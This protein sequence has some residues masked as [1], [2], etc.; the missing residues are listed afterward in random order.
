MTKDTLEPRD[1]LKRSAHIAVGIPVSLAA[2]LR[3]R[4]AGAR[5]RIEGVRDRISDEARDVFARSV[6]EGEHVV[7]TVRRRVQGRRDRIEEAVGGGVA[8][9]TDVGRGVATML[10][11]PFV[12]VDQIDGIGPAYAEKLARAGVMSTRALIERCATSDA[13]ARLADQ[14]DVPSA[15]IERW[16]AAADL[17]RVDG[18]GEEHM[19]LLNRLGVPSVDALAHEDPA[20][21]RARTIALEN[22][23]P[24]RVSAVPSQA[25]F[26]GWIEQAAALAR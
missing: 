7:D 4:I 24:G 11:E 3:D 17:T 23:V 2:N 21:L 10:T 12:P 15:L 1:A 8:A 13:I 5:D 6:D 22:D 19:S 26:A 20:D 14:T 16:A 25:T 18:I 9:A